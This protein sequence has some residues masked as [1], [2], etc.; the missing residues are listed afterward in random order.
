VGAHGASS[1]CRFSWAREECQVVSTT[2]DR[3]D[4]HNHRAGLRHG[5]SVGRAVLQFE[6]L[7]K[8]SFGRRRKR[9]ERNE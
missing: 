3:A 7:T 2:F 9:C 4:E 8:G 6:W 5:I 1:S